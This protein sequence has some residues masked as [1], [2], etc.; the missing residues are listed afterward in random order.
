MSNHSF[1]NYQLI[2]RIALGGMAEVWL[3]K[4]TGIEGFNRHVVVKRILP[5]LAEDP[6]FVQMFLN[7]AKIASRFNHTNIAQIFD[8]GETNGQYFIAMEFIHG[9]DLG[10]VMRRAWTTRQWFARHIALRIIAEACQ[11][12]HYA[13]TRNDDQGRPLRVVHRDVSPQNI[14]ISFEGAVKLVDFGIAKASDQVSNTRSGAIKGKFAYMPPEQAAG[15]P[16]DARTDVF[17]LG[18]VLY[19]L[20]TGVRPLKRDTEI[21]TLQAALECRIEAPSQVAEV[22]VELDDVVMRALAK[23]PDERYVDAREFQRALEKVLLDSKELATSAELSEL[24]TTL[25]SERLVEEAHLGVPVALLES[26]SATVDGRK[27]SVPEVPIESPA[28]TLDDENTFE[29]KGPEQISPPRVSRAEVTRIA[30][31]EEVSQISGGPQKRVIKRPSVSNL[32]SQV[33][34][35]SERR[36]NTNTGTKTEMAEEGAGGVMASNPTRRWELKAVLAGAVLVSTL[37]LLFLFR[38]PLLG[39][40]GISQKQTAVRLSVTCNETVEVTVKPP[41][42]ARARQLLEL[43]FTP[44]T[45]QGGAFVGDTVILTNDTLGIH[46]EEVVGELVEAQSLKH[47]NKIFK[48]RQVRVTTVPPLRE[49]TI[50]RGTSELGQAGRNSNLS[51]MGPGSHLLEV[52]SDQLV[53]QLP[54]ILKIPESGKSVVDVEVDVSSDLAKTTP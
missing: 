45:E 31:Q 20:V 29:E 36:S 30:P 50:W 27:E 28:D 46:Y 52:H 21:A 32:P 16:L 25:F 2:K 1:G 38:D 23:R 10:R 43:G 11:G 47:I 40:V 14:L 7:E 37:G 3:A 48:E 13:H 5:H 24:M 49:A 42:G 12:L 44:L 41:E 9:E 18:L 51:L 22:P 6:E 8:L 53:R 39:V 26:G 19:E 33:S 34:N 17:A 54:F 4:Q 15:K 35:P